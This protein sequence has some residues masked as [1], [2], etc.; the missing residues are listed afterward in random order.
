MPGYMKKCGFSAFKSSWF[1]CSK[2][3][4]IVAMFFGL[5]KP[6]QLRQ[7]LLFYLFFGEIPVPLLRRKYA[8]ILAC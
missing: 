1:C 8:S 6:G 2:Q 5:P 3:F 4:V 7:E